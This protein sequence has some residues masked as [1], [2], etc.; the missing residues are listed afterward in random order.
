MQQ[1]APGRTNKAIIPQCEGCGHIITV[2][3]GKVCK[4]YADPAAK[5]RFGPCNFA[6]HVQR[7]IETETKK[8]N[9]LKAAKRS[10][11]GKA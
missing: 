5:W 3:E 11:K 1:V 10:A 8:V 6:T 7:T 9:P 2:G 4:A